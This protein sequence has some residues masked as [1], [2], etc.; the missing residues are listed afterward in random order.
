MEKNITNRL[1]KL[2]HLP[3]GLYWKPSDFT[4]GNFSLK[5][6]KVYEKNNSPLDINRGH[7]NLTVRLP[8][9]QSSNCGKK[10]IEV[11]PNSYA[12]RKSMWDVVYMDIPKSEWMKEYVQEKSETIIENKTITFN[13]FV[14]FKEE[15][16]KK[17]GSETFRDYVNELNSIGEDFVLFGAL[18]N[19]VKAF[20][21]KYNGK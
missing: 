17:Q 2:K 14:E 10:I 20:I 9:E 15:W 16:A 7:N 13:S 21:E 3:T 6:G 12:S 5:G 19:L 18:D 8:M 1:F 11:F 4:N